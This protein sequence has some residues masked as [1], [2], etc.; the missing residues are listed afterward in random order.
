M[1]GG[2]LSSRVITC[3]RLRGD[4]IP[5]CLALKMLINPLT[6]SPPPSASHSSDYSSDYY[7]SHHGHHSSSH[8]YSS[9][10]PSYINPSSS[11]SWSSSNY[12][13]SSFSY[14]SSE[15]SSTDYWSSYSYSSYS[16]YSSSYYTSSYSSDY[17]ADTCIQKLNEAYSCVK[18]TDF[19][20][21]PCDDNCLKKLIEAIEEEECDEED[22]T[23]IDFIQE[24]LN[25]GWGVTRVQAIAAKQIML[26]YM[27]FCFDDD[28]DDEDWDYADEDWDMGEYCGDNQFDESIEVVECVYEAVYADDNEGMQIDCYEKKDCDTSKFVRNPH[29]FLEVA[30]I[31]DEN[32]EEVRLYRTPTHYRL[33]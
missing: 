11:L 24:S 29:C 4:V 8:Q 25:N 6:L 12:Y 27:E 10:W 30:D 5:V 14:S 15:Y 21:D 20:D 33:F 1:N 17:Y 26:G 18:D 9:D 23:D 22:L 19:G 13:S 3:A 7:S 2:G 32:I 31:M 16:S 28:N